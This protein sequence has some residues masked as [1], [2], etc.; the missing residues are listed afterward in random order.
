MSVEIDRREFLRLSACVGVGV[1]AAGVTGC[2][3]QAEEISVE[4]PSS[5]YGEESQMSERVLVGYATRTGST[6]GV[7]ETIARTLGERGFAVDVRP[8]REHPSLDGYDACVLGSAINGG[9]WLPEA[10][11]W[12]E[13]NATALG[14]MPVA[15]FCVHSMNGGDDER[16]TRKRLAYLDKVRGVITPAAEGFFLGKGPTAEDTSLIARWAFKA[17]GGTAEGDA[18]DWDTIRGWAEQVQL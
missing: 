2:A 1:A 10:M 7:A 11:S 12:L 14:K 6:V 3:P 4:T 5:S 15:A 13:S 16:Q 17:F 18:R 9:A 8:L